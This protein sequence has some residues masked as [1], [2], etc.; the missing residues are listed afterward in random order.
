MIY[1]VTL[2]PAIDR[3][4]SVPSIEFDAVLR[5]TGSRV[6]CGGKGFNVSRMVAQLGGTSVAL[7]FVGG[8]SG[9]FLQDRMNALG[10]KTDF[11]QVD[12]ET[13][14]N[15][16]IVT[17]DGRYIKVNEKGGRV[18]AEAR[19]QFLDQV[20]RLAA[21]NDWWVLAGSLPPDISADFYAQ[22]TTILTQAGAN[23]I[24]DAS[25]ESLRLGCAA[26]PFLIKPNHIEAEQLTG[27]AD[28]VNAAHKLQQMGVQN[29]VISQGAAGALLIDSSDSHHVP[30]PKIQERNPIGAGDAM[31]G[32]IV[33]GLQNNLSLRESLRWGIACGSMAAS[34]DGTAFGN[35]T[36]VETLLASIPASS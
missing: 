35:R 8:R 23:V 19:Q 30:T 15:V 4:V 33:W 12:D 20:Q 27:D 25:G 21:P 17:A 1:T 7:G 11:V 3:E 18:S 29:I 31:V 22:L 16:S 2:N 9:Q 32:G 28:P 26:G 6:D 5:A 34:L 36:E 10:I 14:T 24:L 13:R